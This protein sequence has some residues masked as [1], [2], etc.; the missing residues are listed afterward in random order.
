MNERYKAL[1]DRETASLKRRTGTFCRIGSGRPKASDLY[2]SLSVSTR[3]KS[4][5]KKTVCVRI[6]GETAKAF[7]FEEGGFITMDYDNAPE[8]C[9]FAI[10][11]ADERTGCA[12]YRT[13]SE[14]GLRTAFTPSEEDLKNLFADEQR[15]YRCELKH[16]DTASDAFIFEETAE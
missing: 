10:R 14:T 5:R 2:V 1:I 6:H 12:L 11:K 9:M 15:G 13:N 3:R 16:H 4:G 8:G 7:G